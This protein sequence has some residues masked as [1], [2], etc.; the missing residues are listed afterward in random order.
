MSALRET[1]PVI[2]IPYIPRKHFYA[3][4]NSTSRWIFNCTHR[5]AGKTVAICNHIVKKALENSRTFPPP[6]YAYIGPSFAQAKDL[7]W[8][9]LKY[10]TG[11]LPNVRHVEGELQCVLPTGA[12]I[13]LYGGAAAYERMRGLYFD[14]AALDEYP[15]LNPSVLGTV[16]RPCLADY[17]GWGII[18]GTSN[19]D[20]HF[21]EVKKRSDND[22]D[23]WTQ[24]IV[25]VTDT[26]ALDPD[27]IAEMRK[28][29][30]ADEFAREMMCSFEA[31]VEG[32]Y[33]GEVINDISA[34]NQITGVPYDSSAPVMTW[35][36]LG[37][38][39][40]TFI[41]FVQQCGRELHVI[42]TL[43]NT[44]KGLE[45]YSQQILSKPYSY[46]VH[47]LPHD[48][49]ARELGTG[50]SRYE[51]LVALLNNI[52]VCPSH[53]VEDG[54][55]AARATMRMCYFDKV[56]TDSGL[57]ALK[58]YHKGPTGKPK[59]NWA[60]HAADAFRIGSVALNQV[61]GMISSS[62][63]LPFGRGPLRRNLKRNG[64]RHER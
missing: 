7:V 26:D 37:I 39:D 28:D 13:N 19:G 40:E 21:H 17:Q 15:L 31:P 30:T 6:R 35:W 32:S 20:D 11:G 1:A 50:K 62:N 36:D 58:N 16:V 44:G 8:G 48:V 14:G 59:H 54:I 22:P 29:M 24:L 27:E 5:R 51:I 33:Y 56:R 46:G 55:T 18:S 43:Q 3:L 34:L 2:T 23:K 49:K 4:H 47:V 45:W 12:M 10:Y 52:F 38:D 41:W 57:S 64:T 25:P 63:V 53:T 60:S 9:Y 61:R 42:D